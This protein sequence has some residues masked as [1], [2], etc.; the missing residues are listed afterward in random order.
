MDFN[1]GF[2]CLKVLVE[3]LRIKV[4]LKIKHCRDYVISIFKT[5]YQCSAVYWCN[6]IKI[7]YLNII[8]LPEVRQ[9]FLDI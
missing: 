4:K 1:S 8:N 5:Y 7:K 3:F 6:V 2:S 9:N